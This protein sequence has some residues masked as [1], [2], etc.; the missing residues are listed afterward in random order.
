MNNFFDSFKNFGI[1][2]LCEKLS[3][4]FKIL[5]NFWCIHDSSFF[6][7][8]NLDGAIIT[9]NNKHVHIKGCQNKQKCALIQFNRFVAEKFY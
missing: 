1:V 9:R 6:Q 5:I 2:K 3:N 8:A 7:N 4:I